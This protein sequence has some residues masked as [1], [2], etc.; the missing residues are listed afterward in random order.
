M[1]MQ[2]KWDQTDE[3]VEEKFIDK[4]LFAWLKAISLVV[5]GIIM[6]GLLAEPLIHSVQNLST[7]AS[8]PS[9]FIAFIFVPFASNARIAV[10]AVREA[11]RKKVN[12]NSLTF[13]EVHSSSCHMKRHRN[14]I[15][16]FAHISVKP[17]Q[18][19]GTVLMNNLLG[20]SV[21]LSLVYFR[22]L[23]WEFSIEV[24]MVLIVSAVIGCLAS[25]TTVFPI[26]MAF[27]ACLLYPLSLVL[28]YVL[29]DFDWLS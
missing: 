17:M 27:L 18:I 16:V 22:G 23:S 19:Y 20:F 8:I 1:T 9:F 25:F 4:T 6:L 2:K 29:G 5:L 21:L 11:R 24:L 12:I 3:L 10:S 15:L 13:S 14:Q 26:W 28:V 7:A